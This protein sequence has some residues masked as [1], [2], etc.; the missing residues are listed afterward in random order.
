[1]GFAIAE[2][3]AVHGAK[4]LLVSGP[5][6]LKT[7]H[8]NITRISVTSADEMYAS[9]HEYF[10]DCDGAILSAAVA[11]YKPVEISDTK[12]KK[13]EE[14]LVIKLVKNKDILASLGKIKAGKQLLVGFSLETHNE[15]EFAL[16]KMRRKNCDFIV[17]NSLRDKGAGFGKD[18]NK[19]TILTAKDQEITFPVKRKTE[20][21]EDITAF[22]IK[23]Y[24]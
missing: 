23:N 21:A 10:P 15:K 24:F 4:V 3:L 8:T 9:C 14:D 18:T 6:N 7:G 19:I 5:T 22:I 11:D 16:E 1:M 2:T 12:I 13:S 20:V 17:L